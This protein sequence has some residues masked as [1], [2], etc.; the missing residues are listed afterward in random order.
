VQVEPREQGGPKTRR[1]RESRD[2][3]IECA[4]ELIAERGVERVGLDDVLT[5]AGVGKG[6]LY[7]YFADRDALIEAAVARSCAQVQH[8]LTGMFGGL[9]SIEQL[10][11]QLEVLAQVF[12]QTLAGCPIGRLAAEVADRNQGAQRQVETAFG[13]WERMFADLFTRLRKRGG[14]RPGADPSALATALLAAL[15]GGQLLGQTRKEAASLRIASAAALGYI[16]TFAA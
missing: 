7:H 13:A 8:V 1:G 4:A 15:E 12:E 2:R 16:R 3:I 10:E 6:Q 14:L 5:A 9:D 11:Q